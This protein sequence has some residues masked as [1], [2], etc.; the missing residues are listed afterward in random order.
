MFTN[1]IERGFDMKYENEALLVEI[2][3]L[4][5]TVSEEQQRIAG[6]IRELREEHKKLA[7]EVRLSNFVLTNI[8]ARNEII[9]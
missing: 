4:L 3:G 9:N 8:T 6:E 5:K 7:D 1:L 2:L